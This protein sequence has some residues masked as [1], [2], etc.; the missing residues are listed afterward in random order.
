MRRYD[1]RLVAAQLVLAALL[2]ALCL[3]VPF[4]WVGG[5]HGPI[6]STVVSPRLSSAMI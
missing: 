5:F 2:V 3:P 1:R 6:E 4:L